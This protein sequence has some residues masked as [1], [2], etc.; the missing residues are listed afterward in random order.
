[1]L[2]SLRSELLNQLAG[3]LG[4]DIAE[5]DISLTISNLGVTVLQSDNIT[6]VVNSQR[7]TFLVLG[8][9]NANPT[10]RCNQIRTTREANSNLVV[11]GNEFLIFLAVVLNGLGVVTIG[12]QLT[13]FKENAASGNKSGIAILQ[14]I[15]SFAGRSGRR[16]DGTRSSYSHSHGANHDDSQHQCEYFF[17]C[18]F[19]L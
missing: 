10:L 4:S 8:V 3:S 15:T 6:I 16:I 9:L 19:L 1:M 14:L 13:N 17:H 2:T 18:D 11:L 12:E 5:S 7:S